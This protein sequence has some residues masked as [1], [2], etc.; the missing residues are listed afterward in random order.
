MTVKEAKRAI[1][2][3]LKKSGVKNARIWAEPRFDGKTTIRFRSILTGFDLKTVGVSLEGALC[4]HVSMRTSAGRW[5]T[6]FLQP[7][8]HWSEQHRDMPSMLVY[9]PASASMG[10]AW[11]PVSRLYWQ[12][13]TQEVSGYFI[14]E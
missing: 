8:R 10:G 4:S 5:K 12:P 11:G 3:G 2:A 1:R 9:Q 14:I 13:E 7:R 6:Y